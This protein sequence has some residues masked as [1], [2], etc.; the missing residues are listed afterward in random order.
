MNVLKIVDY[1]K[2]NTYILS[3]LVTL[4]V[5][6]L[7]VVLRYFKDQWKGLRN[8][9]VLLKDQHKIY[10]GNFIKLRNDIDS[11]K[12]SHTALA[13]QVKNIEGS[14]PEK[15]R[16]DIDKLESISNDNEQII[17][18]IGAQVDLILRYRGIDK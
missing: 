6:L 4:T 11:L 8:D 18:K 5:F 10:L 16:E 15:L 1:V 9:N 3:S 7:S 17:T 14:I 12:N 2:D 13:S